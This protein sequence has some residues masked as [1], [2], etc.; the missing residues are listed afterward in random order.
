MDARTRGS[1]GE[2]RVGVRDRRDGL[3]ARRR[4]ARAA[5][6][7]L[8]R[9]SPAVGLPWS[10]D[11]LRDCYQAGAQ[12]FGW[13]RRNPEVGAMRD[14]HWKIG[15]GIAGVNYSWWQV[16]CQ[17]RATISRAGNA[18]VRSAANDPGTRNR[19]RDAPALRR[20]A[21]PCARARS[22]RARGLT[23]PWA[24]C[25]AAPGSP[26]R[27]GTPSTRS[28]VRSCN[29]SWTRSPTTTDRHCAAAAR[30]RVRRSRTHLPAR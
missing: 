2:L 6:T 22:L 28:A 8:R 17:A 21:R 5:A 29:D 19:H 15:Y 10:S 1:R 16:R 18:Y 14:G 30:R 24:Q 4:P 25:P 27:S 7:Q 3:Q 9:G 20:A 23:M 11:A 26:P 12:R 13:S